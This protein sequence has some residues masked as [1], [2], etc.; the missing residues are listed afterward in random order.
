MFQLHEAD[1]GGVAFAPEGLRRRV[2]RRQGR[3]ILTASLVLAALV[4]GGLSIRAS[5]GDRRRPVVVPPSPP[6]SI[7]LQGFGVGFSSDGTR[8]MTHSTTDRRG[9]IY[10]P[11]TATLLQTLSPPRGKGTGLLHAFAPDGTR[12]AAAGGDPRDPVITWVKDTLSGRT[13][14]RFRAACCMGLFSPDGRFFAAPCCIGTRI[15][16]LDTGKRVSD[17]PACCVAA[18]SP[19]SQRILI[20]VGRDEPGDVV[21]YV[22]DVHR[23]GR[24]GPALTLHGPGGA[25]IAMASV[26][27]SPDGSMIALVADGSDPHGGRTVMVFDTQTGERMFAIHP[28]T[29][30]LSVAFAPDSSAI[31]VGG[32]KG[33][34]TVW[35]VSPHPSSPVLSFL[36]HETEVAA[37]AFSPDGR[38]LMTS[39]PLENETKVWDTASL[40]SPE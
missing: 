36:A 38:E 18:F 30:A 17:L 13:V 11:R 19:D 26:A 37:I 21:G 3:T 32:K 22:W 12:F 33:L 35:E 27:W 40:T 14:W 2:R 20:S 1:V 25:N 24:R 39:A 23:Q 5:V 10:D 8:L 15:Y 34:A 31:A 6:I 29:N 4:I 9:F 16:D 7:T 28:S